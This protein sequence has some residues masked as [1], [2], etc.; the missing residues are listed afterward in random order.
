[1]NLTIRLV[2]L[3]FVCSFSVIGCKTE[4]PSSSE[5]AANEQNTAVADQGFSGQDG[6]D[7]SAAI[8]S[9]AGKIAAS[10]DAK[11]K[12]SED[13]AMESESRASKRDSSK[14]DVVSYDAPNSDWLQFRGP[15]GLGTTDAKLPSEFD[16]TFLRWNSELIGRGASTPI[17]VGDNVF[18]TSYSGYGES[19][20]KPGK[21]SELQ[22]HVYCFDRKTGA[23]NWI[24]N[25]KG[26][27]AETT[28]L[29][30][31]L[32]GH[33]FASSTMVSDGE[34]VYAFFGI[35]GVFAFDIEGEFLW[36]Q[37]VGWQF[38]NFGSSAALTLFEDILIVNASIE[39]ETVYGFD[40]K[41]GAGVWKIDDVIESWTTP[42]VGTSSDGK[43]ELVIAQKDIVRGFDPT[44]GKEIWTCEGILDY[45]VPTP[46]VVDGIAY[47]NGGKQN[48]T[49]AIRLGGRGD[50][51]RTH[52][53]WEAEIGAN[54]TSSAVSGENIFQIT[55][56][57]ILQVLDRKT[58]EVLKRERIKN[59]GTKFYASPT[60]SNGKIFFP[61]THGIAV[62]DASPEIDLVSLNKITDADT[63]FRASIAVSGNDMFT[64]NDKF[65][66]C[67]APR[68][69]ESK[70]VKLN[71]KKSEASEQ[72]VSAAKYDFDL[73]TGRIRPYNRALVK[74][75]HMLRQF[76]L[77]PYK[78]VIT[79]KQTA[80]SLELIRAEFPKFE[81]K[82][83]ERHELI[84]KHTKKELSDEEF[85][86]QIAALDKEVMAAQIAIRTK[87]K[88]MF[89]KEQMDKHMEEHRAWLE[90]NKKK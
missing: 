77:N 45:I 43:T 53:M 70:L 40:K 60:L 7:E 17:I 50:V 33:G 31:N 16:P 56:P 1:M 4:A 25:I 66:Y 9:T 19:L 86:E 36:Q 14:P 72:I 42:V 76:F 73:K 13:T 37:G 90:K 46:V 49:L 67:I 59:A 62:V 55:D 79:E 20:E 29:N 11:S 39:S 54:V 27:P 52:K 51:T 32:I 12:T 2:C 69:S 5:G 84:W 81:A 10:D 61:L 83:T 74:T 87:I 26:N 68:K 41:S 78:S 64:R 48:R 35:G 8:P 89:T 80:L 44:N 28:R 38:H 63:E 22:Y 57:G 34:R 30:P 6:A 75:P 58:G 47:C 24:R 3:F 88:A 82:R 71:A 18:L 15:D 23:L 21:I 65:L 85:N